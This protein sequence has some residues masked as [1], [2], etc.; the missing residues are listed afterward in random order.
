MDLSK[1]E[2]AEW[3]NFIPNDISA[4]VAKTAAGG[5]VD[6]AIPSIVNNNLNSELNNWMIQPSQQDQHGITIQKGRILDN[7]NGLVPNDSSRHLCPF[8]FVQPSQLILTPNT[9]EQ[10]HPL[11][12][13]PYL[14]PIQ[15]PSA[16]E[17]GSGESLPQ[18]ALQEHD[19]QHAG[20]QPSQ[21]A[22]LS[23]GESTR[24]QLISKRSGSEKLRAY[25]EMSAK[26]HKGQPLRKGQPKPKAWSKDEINTLLTLMDTGHTTKEVYEAL[27]SS[28]SLG[29]IRPKY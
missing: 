5:K 8:K 23:A 26:I 1:T 25:R 18:Y 19:L 4:N 16:F 2:V 29:S 3:L 6:D 12:W 7:Q 28:K 10:D 15:T 24:N 21:T 9:I 17:G 27:N 13:P 22:E 20:V 14:A 11:L